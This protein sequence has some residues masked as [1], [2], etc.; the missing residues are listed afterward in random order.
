MR[1]G[2]TGRELPDQGKSWSRDSRVPESTCYK[3][4]W[5]GG[6]PG[7]PSITAQVTCFVTPQYN[8][9]IYVTLDVTGYFLEGGKGADLQQV[10]NG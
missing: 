1:E 3:G 8:L 7:R 4:K 10:D 2:G 9:R 6:C 5:G